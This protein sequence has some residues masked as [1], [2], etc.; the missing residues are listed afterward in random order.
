[1]EKNNRMAFPVKIKDQILTMMYN[2]RW[3]MEG[4]RKQYIWYKHNCQTKNIRRKYRRF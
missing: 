2:M 1:M 3:N 4:G